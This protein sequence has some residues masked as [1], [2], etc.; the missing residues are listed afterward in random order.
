M[1]EERTSILY[2]SLIGLKVC[3]FYLSSC[4]GV[5]APSPILFNDDEKSFVKDLAQISIMTFNAARSF[6]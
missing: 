1:Q 3:V 5:L 4:S 2:L 6:L